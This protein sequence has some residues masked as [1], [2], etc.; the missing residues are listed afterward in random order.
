MT[1]ITTESLKEIHKHLTQECQ[2]FAAKSMLAFAE[3]RE[4][5]G[6]IKND[7]QSGQSTLKECCDALYDEL[8]VLESSANFKNKLSN[9]WKSFD[10]EIRTEVLDF[11]DY[12][13]PDLTPREMA[14]AYDLATDRNYIDV[15]IDKFNYQEYLPGKQ[16]SSENS[17]GTEIENAD[18]KKRKNSALFTSDPG[19]KK[20]INAHNNR[21]KRDLIKPSINFLIN[22]CKKLKVEKEYNQN[23]SDSEN[24]TR[25]LLAR[26]FI[27]LA[28]KPEVRTKIW[29]REYLNV[30]FGKS[31]E[32]L[33][34][35]FSYPPTDSKPAR[36]FNECLDDLRNLFKDS[37]IS[38][39]N[40]GR[41]RT[42]LLQELLLSIFHCYISP[43]YFNK[44]NI[45]EISQELN[46]KFGMSWNTLMEENCEYMR[47]KCPDK[48]F[49]DLYF[50]G[51][52]SR[53]EYY[54]IS[55]AAERSLVKRI[56][57]FSIRNFKSIGYPLVFE[58]FNKKFIEFFKC[59]GL[60][61]NVKNNT[62]NVVFLD[63]IAR[64]FKR[65]LVLLFI[66]AVADMHT[67][68]DEFVND[69]EKIRESINNVYP[70]NVDLFLQ[71]KCRDILVKKIGV[72][73]LGKVSLAMINSC[74]FK[75]RERITALKVMNN[76]QNYSV[77]MNSFKTYEDAL[78]YVR[79]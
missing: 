9:S 26:L 25:L 66:D 29:N 32:G 55:D 75:D 31:T 58:L 18:A 5:Y 56:D 15:P 37:I 43:A 73:Y 51:Q 12:L 79:S 78:N 3:A 59:Y 28:R 39:F 48:T 4:K 47:S 24:Q 67:D 72:E 50:L 35:I 33:I 22:E 21:Y 60:D 17:S 62:G 14:V 71:P 11:R 49:G 65:H 64:Q 36:N 30:I 8:T 69:L 16:S 46:N 74:V 7:I 42:E 77:Y 45:L 6:F 27:K 63:N 23:D 53:P 68:K 54:K 57:D 76:H 20:R 40:F 2:D 34:K 70:E 38:D 44:E 13:S 19:I 52:M 61:K 10:T 41:I 1:D